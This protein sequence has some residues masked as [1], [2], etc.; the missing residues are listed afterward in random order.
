[1]TDDAQMRVLIARLAR[2]HRSGGLVVERASLLASGEDFV[3]LEEWITRAGGTP[4]ATATA[5]RGGGG[6]HGNRFAVPAADK[7]PQRY[8]LPPGAL[9]A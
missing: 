5:T 3:A 6:L 8:I 7:L 1:M 9:D 2:P 4:E